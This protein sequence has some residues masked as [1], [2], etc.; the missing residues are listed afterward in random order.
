[1]F[2]H[3]DEHYTETGARGLKRLRKKIDGTTKNIFQIELKDG[4]SNSVKNDH[5]ASYYYRVEKL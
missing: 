3:P 4:A 1:M 5:F 2:V